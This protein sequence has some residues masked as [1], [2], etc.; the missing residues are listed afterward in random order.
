M[1]SMFV[2]ITRSNIK[3]PECYRLMSIFYH[4]MR[5]SIGNKQAWIYNGT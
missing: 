3:H 2:K 1:E 5:R 4:D